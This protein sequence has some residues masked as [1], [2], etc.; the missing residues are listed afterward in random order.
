MDHTVTE[1]VGVFV[2]F[3]RRFTGLAAI[4]WVSTDTPAACLYTS[5]RFIGFSTN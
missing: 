1:V 4:K 3:R 5:S 2:R